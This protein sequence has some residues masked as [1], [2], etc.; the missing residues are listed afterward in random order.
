[1]L[2]GSYPFVLTA[3]S[4][5]CSGSTSCRVRP[6]PY[7]PRSVLLPW[8]RPVPRMR[9]DAISPAYV[10]PY[11]SGS[12]EHR[13]DLPRPRTWLLGQCRRGDGMTD[14]LVDGAA[15]VD[16]RVRCGVA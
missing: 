5:G 16:G 13:I 14:E 11:S 3:A 2:C 12:R 10:D 15:A 1:M 7:F 6:F 4:C 9:G 8:Q